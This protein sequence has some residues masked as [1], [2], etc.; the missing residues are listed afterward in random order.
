MESEML[1][2]A[3]PTRVHC[4]HTLRAP[5]PGDWLFSETTQQSRLA[6]CSS[7]RFWRVP[8]PG[9]VS[10]GARFDQAVGR[11]LLSSTP[12]LWLHGD[13]MRVPKLVEIEFGI[14]A[15]ILAIGTAFAAVRWL[16]A[17]VASL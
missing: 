12:P 9:D 16:L 1:T 7:A 11:I 4:A 3:G 8:D 15:C 17:M 13:I 5:D 6:I 10:R 2:R 14:L